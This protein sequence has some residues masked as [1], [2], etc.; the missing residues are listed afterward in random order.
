MK[1]S[2]QARLAHWFTVYRMG[3][4]AI[5][6]AG[7]MAQ[8]DL[9]SRMIPKAARLDV[10]RSPAEVDYRSFQG[11]SFENPHVERLPLQN[12]TK[13]PAGGASMWPGR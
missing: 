13:W 1:F 11:I 10:E 6:I 2:K 12:I 4:G 5:Q 9:T 7:A 8:R 3:E